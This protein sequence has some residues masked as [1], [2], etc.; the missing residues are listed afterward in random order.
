M[1][2]LAAWASQPAPQSSPPLLLQQHL[3]EAAGCCC[4]TQHAAAAKV[5]AADDMPAA[6]AVAGGAGNSHFGGDSL[7]ELGEA[8]RTAKWVCSGFAALPAASDR[9][10]YML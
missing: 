5:P 4:S 1:H 10:A 7:L 2:T 9:L 3:E 6:D 8:G